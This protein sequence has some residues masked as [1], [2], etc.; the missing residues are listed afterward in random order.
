MERISTHIGIVV[1][2]IAL[3]LTVTVTMSRL[4]GELTTSAR[5]EP[6]LSVDPA[7]VVTNKS[8]KSDRVELDVAARP[9]KTNCVSEG[10]TTTCTATK[11]PDRM[12]R[13]D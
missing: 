11:T 13:L 12:A 7:R 5:A 4:T 8:D 6:V 3:S 1:I 9:L 2:A 10:T